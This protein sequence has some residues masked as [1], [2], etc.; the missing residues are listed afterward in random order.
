MSWH[1][2]FFSPGLNHELLSPELASQEEALEEAWRL[3]QSGEDIT[4]IEGPEG[5][6]VSA[7]EIEVWFRKREDGVAPA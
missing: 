3:A 2:R 5:E 4:A 7:E 1:V 6:L